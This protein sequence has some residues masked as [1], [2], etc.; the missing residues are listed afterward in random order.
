MGIPPVEEKQKHW[1]FPSLKNYVHYSWAS[2]E[3]IEREM[4]VWSQ[5]QHL[6]MVNMINDHEFTLY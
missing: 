4:Q 5:V 1:N 3:Q 6:Y 2:L